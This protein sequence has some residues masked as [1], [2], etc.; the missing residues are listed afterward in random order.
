MKTLDS[1]IL[2]KWSKKNK[3]CQ[4]SLKI[5]RDNGRGGKNWTITKDNFDPSILSGLSQKNKNLSDFA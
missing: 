5:G 3:S 4:I 2:R 1:H